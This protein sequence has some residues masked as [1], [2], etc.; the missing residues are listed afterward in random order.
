MLK[1]WPPRVLRKEI[2]LRVRMSFGEGSQELQVLLAFAAGEFTCYKITDCILKNILVTFKSMVLVILNSLSAFRNPALVCKS[3]LFSPLCPRGS[4]FKFS[5]RSQNQQSPQAAPCLETE[6]GNCLNWK[7]CNT[8]KFW[9]ICSG[10]TYD[11]FK[12]SCQQ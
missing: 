4:A 7:T 5:S 1:A 6:S 11:Y 3:D 12:C 8:Q 2:Q 10:V 9:D